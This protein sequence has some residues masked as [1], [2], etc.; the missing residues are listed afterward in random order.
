[1]RTFLKF[2]GSSLLALVSASAFSADHRVTVGG[3][4][5]VFSPK[6][7]TINAGDTVTFVNAGGFHNVAAN[8]G[9]F[10]SGDPTS[11]AFT[12]TQAFPTAGTF[13]YYCEIHGTSNGGG[14]AGSITVADVA[15]PPPAGQ[16][17]NA[18]ISGSW[19]DQQQSGHGFL[20][21]VIPGNVIVAYWFVYTPDG[22]AQSWLVAA[23]AYD[24]T[25]SSV[26][27]EAFQF[28]FENLTT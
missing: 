6:T 25:K 5:L 18:G 13:G 23:G 10:R 14:M 26:T 17:I 24:P 7:L 20:L 4:A 9:S 28:F 15:P 8:D 12:F 22:T 1:M 16:L 2:F 3:S 11:D 27:L 21:Q 19:F